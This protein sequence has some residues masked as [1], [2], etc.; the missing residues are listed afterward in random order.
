[1][2]L[3]TDFED[4]RTVWQ[5]V[6]DLRDS[7]EADWEICPHSER[8]DHLM[9]ANSSLRTAMEGLEEAEHHLYMASVVTE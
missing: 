7:V 4:C 8:K 1:M 2:A 9:A 6:R 3:V 5:K